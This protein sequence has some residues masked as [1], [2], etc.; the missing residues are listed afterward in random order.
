MLPRIL[1]VFVC[2]ILGVFAKTTSPS[3]F[4]EDVVT[5]PPFESTNGTVTS[6][7]IETFIAQSRFYRQLKTIYGGPEGGGCEGTLGW[8]AAPLDTH[9]STMFFHP[10]LMK[11]AIDHSEKGYDADAARELRLDGV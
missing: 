10:Q 4:H 3:T 2:F 7:K 9:L 8:T 11:A 1:M 5:A 6:E